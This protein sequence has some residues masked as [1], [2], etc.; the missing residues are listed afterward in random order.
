ME[1]RCIVLGATGVGKTALVNS[2]RNEIEKRT[3]STIGVDYAVYKK[4]NPCVK[5]HIWDT[6]GSKRFEYVID[7]FL[8]KVDVI[9]FVYNCCRSFTYLLQKL[10]EVKRKGFGK[11][12]CI[13]SYSHPHLG[14][15]IA[16]K[17]GYLFVNITS[18]SQKLQVFNMLAAFCYEENKRCHFLSTKV[19][20]PKERDSGYCWFSFC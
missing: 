4:E 10:K 12:F 9:I 19:D 3:T 17:Y 8:K 11:R 14:R 1:I 13:V 6:S 2:V 5:V 16:R 20:Y 18:E 7:I 15:A